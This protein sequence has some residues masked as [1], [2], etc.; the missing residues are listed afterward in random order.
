MRST[1]VKTVQGSDL[2]RKRHPQ[3][4]F[5][6]LN[7]L[8]CGSWLQGGE[9]LWR[10]FFEPCFDTIPACLDGHV[11]LL[12]LTAFLARFLPSLSNPSRHFRKGPGLL[13]FVRRVATFRSEI[14]NQR[15]SIEH[16]IFR[17]DSS[18]SQHTEGSGHVCPKPLPHLWK[19]D[20]GSIFLQ[21]EIV[22]CLRNHNQ[23]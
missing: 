7:I 9:F 19:P 12:C 15:F 10:I 2:F 11:F 20:G 8:I 22:P 1:I 23:P 18:R 21:V 13:S 3:G 6:L 16:Q 4:C 17:T 5:S 14:Y